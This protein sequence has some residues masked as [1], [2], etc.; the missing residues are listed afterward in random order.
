MTML[1]PMVGGPADGRFV[2][3]NGVTPAVEDVYVYVPTPAD[4]TRLPDPKDAVPTVKARYRLARGGPEGGPGL[5]YRYVAD[6]P[7][8]KPAMTARD[9][10]HEAICGDGCGRARRCERTDRLI[11]AFAHEQ[12]DRARAGIALFEDHVGGFQYAREMRE[13]IDVVDPTVPDPEGWDF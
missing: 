3:L 7:S 4:W 1:I 11:D 6:E 10:L 8:P 12:A 2:G 13:I 9:D 5:E